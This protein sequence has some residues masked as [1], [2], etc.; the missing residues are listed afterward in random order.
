MKANDEKYKYLT[1]SNMTFERWM[2]EQYKS[3]RTSDEYY[4]DQYLWPIYMQL[5]HQQVW[6]VLPDVKVKNPESK[7]QNPEKSGKKSGKIF[8]GQFLLAEASFF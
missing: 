5:F 4:Y 6:S 1:K 8:E 3:R 7:C 2:M